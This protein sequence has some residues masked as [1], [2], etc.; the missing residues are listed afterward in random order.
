[1]GEVVQ[2]IARA[3]GAGRL[4]AVQPARRPD[5]TALLGALGEGTDQRALLEA[6]KPL[7]EEL[8]DRYGFSVMRRGLPTEPEALSAALLTL[9]DAL[10]ELDVQVGGR[11]PLGAYGVYLGQAALTWFEDG[12]G[13]TTGLAVPNGIE[14]AALARFIRARIVADRDRA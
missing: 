3:R 6:A 2:F 11:R 8:R 10:A 1:M 7:L 4:A 12:Y 5:S 14:P 13:G 9:A